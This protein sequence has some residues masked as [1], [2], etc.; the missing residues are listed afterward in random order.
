MRRG[1]WRGLLCLIIRVLEYP[2]HRLQG[3]RRT[4]QPGH[5][6]RDLWDRLENGYWI[7]DGTT[8]TAHTKY[9]YGASVDVIHNNMSPDCP[10]TTQW[11]TATDYSGVPIGWTYTKGNYKPCV[12]VSYFPSSS[13]AS[14]GSRY[15]AGC[16]DGSPVLKDERYF[17][18]C[19]VD[20]RMTKSVESSRRDRDWS[21]FPSVC[22][23]SSSRL[24]AVAPISP[25]GCRT[26]V[27][28]GL[29]H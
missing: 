29:A 21:P 24:T 16:S 25:V 2:E 23:I 20:A 9:C 3:A 22:T 12:Q 7:Y 15:E 11:F 26:V 14:G 10:G 5:Q 1:H 18:A 13:L 27:R 4:H 19:D 6:Q 28:D 8:L 17:D